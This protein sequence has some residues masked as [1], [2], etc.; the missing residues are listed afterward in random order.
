MPSLE[1]L[2]QDIDNQRIKYLGL[3]QKLATTLAAF[4]APADASDHLISYAEEFGPDHAIKKLGDDRTFFKVDMPAA[5]RREIAPLV[6]SIVDTTYSL[7]GL[8]GEREDMLAK[9]DPKRARVYMFFGRECTLDEGKGTMT[10]LDAPDKP[11]PLNL[12]VVHTKDQPAPPKGRQ[13]PPQDKDREP[14]R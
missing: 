14:S 3:R 4:K 11:Q 5:V 7:D 1:K 2:Q 9:S 12:Q 6:L 8:V 13:L 10:F